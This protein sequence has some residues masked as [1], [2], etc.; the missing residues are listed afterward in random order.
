MQEKDG[1]LSC[2]ARFTYKEEADWY[3][4]NVWNATRSNKLDVVFR[5]LDIKMKRELIILGSMSPLNDNET[6][7]A[8][9]IL[10]A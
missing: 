6:L 10:A 9:L 7:A 3:A 1:N 8:C 4:R 2:R 5:V